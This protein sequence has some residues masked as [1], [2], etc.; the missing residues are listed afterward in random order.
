MGDGT[1]KT[2]P[3]MVQGM[4]SPPPFD[5]AGHDHS[6]MILL[7][8]APCG[9][10]ACTDTPIKNK[11]PDLP[12]PEERFR[13]L[14]YDS[15]TSGET[16]SYMEE[17][18]RSLNLCDGLDTTP[19]TGEATPT[20]GEGMPDDT[21]IIFD[22]D[23]TLL[24][25]SAINMNQWDSA[26]L[27]V[28]ADTVEGVLRSAARLGEVLIVTNGVDWWVS[29]SARR[30]MPKLLPLLS[31]L[32]VKSARASWEHLYP[33]DPFA[34]K[35]EAFRELL[36]PRQRSANI[37]VLG[38]SLAEIEAARG[39]R[40]QLVD[41]SLVKT[42][43]FKEVPSADQVIGQLRSVAL[44]LSELVHQRF[45]CSRVLVPRLLPEQLLHLVGCATGWRL[46][47]VEDAVPKSPGCLMKAPSSI[48][49]TRPALPAQ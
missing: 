8:A 27:E 22:W 12:A 34:W 7:Q 49:L 15:D 39:V 33:G 11:K 10:Q 35:R 2:G 1:S 4:T 30:F 6:Q 37:L 42:V 43:K 28:L 17:S 26:Q 16:E 20:L 21:I 40:P 44:E 31:T 46:E 36:L 23:D 41:G 5:P 48:M 38:D 32:T 29:D 24:C 14:A 18:L 9:L 3:V 19:T 47:D 45:S 25:S 13:T